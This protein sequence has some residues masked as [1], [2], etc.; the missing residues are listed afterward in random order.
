MKVIFSLLIG[1]SLY[2]VI[3]STDSS[4]AQHEQADSYRYYSEGETRWGACSK[5]W[6]KKFR[7]MYGALTASLLL[8][9]VL[10]CFLPDRFGSSV[11]VTGTIF[12]KNRNFLTLTQKIVSSNL[13]N[14]SEKSRTASLRIVLMKRWLLGIKQVSFT[15]ISKNTALVR[16]N[17]FCTFSITETITSTMLHPSILKLIPVFTFMKNLKKTVGVGLHQSR[18]LL[19]L[20]PQHLSNF[21]AVFVDF[22]QW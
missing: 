4:S 20:L 9:F 3:S 16:A 19:R 11:I 22:I 6:E 17:K 12:F 14:I 21:S 8:S 18:Y 7:F 15:M 1:A 5:Y 2:M 10:H 13:K